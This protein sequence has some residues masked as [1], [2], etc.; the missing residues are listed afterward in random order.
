MSRWLNADWETPNSVAND[1]SVQPDFEKLAEASECYGV[2]VERP[3]ELKMALENALK[4]NKEGI[5]A[6]VNVIIEHNPAWG[7]WGAWGSGAR[8]IPRSVP[9]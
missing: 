7:P 1:R 8:K 4:A 3:S 9:L 6:V 5:P 2:R